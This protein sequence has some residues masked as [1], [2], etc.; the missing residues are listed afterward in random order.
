[1]KTFT[2]IIGKDSDTNLYVGYIPGFP[3]AHSQG[4]TLDELQ[5]NL[6]EVIEMIL[7]D[8]NLV[9]E[10]EFIGTQQIVIR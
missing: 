1:M 2:A 4:E 8:D 10:T 7:E 3:G 6:R 5:E 9:I